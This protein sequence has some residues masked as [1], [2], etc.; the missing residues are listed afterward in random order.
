MRGL[1]HKLEHPGPVE[2]EIMCRLLAREAF[3]MKQFVDAVEAWR[4]HPER[5]QKTAE[6]EAKNS[7]L[8]E[9]YARV[10]QHVIH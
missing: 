4:A 1:C 10:G 2:E 3:S 8:L 5:L 6:A 9:A 7:D